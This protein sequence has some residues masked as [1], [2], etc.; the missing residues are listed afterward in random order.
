[1]YYVDIQHF[2]R[3]CEKSVKCSALGSRNTA[4]ISVPVVQVFINIKASLKLNDIIYKAS[5][6]PSWP[7]VGLLRSAF[8]IAL[9]DKQTG[10]VMK[11]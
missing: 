6:G 7:C 1:M 8:S 3:Y 4:V 5:N 2:C 9:A 11:K 10:I